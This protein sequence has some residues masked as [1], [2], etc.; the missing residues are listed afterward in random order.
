MTFTQ[1]IHDNWRQNQ[2]SDRDVLKVYKKRHKR[3]QKRLQQEMDRSNRLALLLGLAQ[4]SI[5]NA[6]MI[7]LINEELKFKRY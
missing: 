7:E 3:L 6:L 2:P 4:N 1:R 5:N